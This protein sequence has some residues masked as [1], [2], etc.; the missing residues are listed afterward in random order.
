MT[1][2]RTK[3]VRVRVV[4]PLGQLACHSVGD[5]LTPGGGVRDIWLRR[6]WVEIVSEV[7]TAVVGPV[8]CAALRVE[9]PQPRRK[10]GRP[11]K[12]RP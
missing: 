2:M 3:E 11:R 9:T 7:E 5:I 12:V 10:P 8:E 1:R 4:K 6:G